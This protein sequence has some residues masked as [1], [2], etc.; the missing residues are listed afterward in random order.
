VHQ[1]KGLE[2]DIVII[3]DLAAKTGRSTNG[4]TFFSDRWGILV[5]AAYG[6][7]RK[8]LPHSLILEAKELEDD[9]QYEEEK[10]LLYVAV[11]RARKMLVL[12][13]G[14][15]RQ[16]GPWLQW[17]SQVLENAQPGAI[18]KAREGTLQTAKFKG[19]QV[20]L[21]PASQLNVPEQLEFS[22]GS[23]LI[24]EPEIPLVQTPRVISS[25]EMTPSD[26]LS[27][28]G[29]FRYFHWTRLLGMSEPG[30]E[31]TRDTT[32]MRLGSAAHKIL[33]SGAVPTSA[34]LA[35]AGLADLGLVFESSDWRDLE[36]DSPERE[37]PFIMHLRID[38]RDC[39]IRGRMDAVV[40]GDLPRVV[41]YKYAAWR[42]GVEANY[43]IQMTAYSLALMKA[44]GT[45]SAVG[46][47]WYLKSPMK[48]V[49]H[50]YTFAEADERLRTLMSNYR[51]AI[52]KNEWPAAG[53][54][55]CDRVECGFRPRCWPS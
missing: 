9:Q 35:S 48:I 6:L 11:T 12:G 31:P 51:L 15:S 23:I 27:L 19:F 20:K 30:T 14:F 54:A 3:P 21:V 47:L 8:P 22:A 39:W 32:Q 25:M 53:R 44:L 43:E 38:E 7:H 28:D 55:Y 17:M 18:E 40:S 49:R 5:G 34:A 41:D 16:S 42:E 10:R 46:E 52:E 29:C 4:R 24:G 26:L 2:F 50:E 45:Q 1:A 37:M 33:E 13:E 36:S